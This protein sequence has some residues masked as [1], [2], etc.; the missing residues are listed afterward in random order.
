MFNCEVTI[1]SLDLNEQQKKAVYCDDKRICVVAG[2]G[3]GK[4][5]TLIQRIGRLIQEDKCRGD[6]IL[7][8]TFTNAAAF[9]M[10]ERFQKAFGTLNKGVPFFGTFHAF[11]YSLIAHDI[12][13]RD[14]VGYTKVPMIVT[15]NKMKMIEKEVATR[16]GINLTEEKLTTG[17]NLSPKEEYDYAIFKKALRHTMREKNVITFNMLCYDVCALFEN[18]YPIV[19]QY[20]K[21]YTYILTDEFQ[22]TDPKQWDFIKSFK[23]SDIMVVGDALQT[24]YS[25]R[26]ASP[27]IIMGLAEDPQWTTIKLYDNYR[28]TEQI[29]K[30]ANKMS[31]YAKE[32]YRIV[33]TAHKTGDP[34]IEDRFS[35]PGWGKTCDDD[36][37]DQLLIDVKK[38]DGECAILCRTN[39]EVKA[40]TE[41][42]QE[43]EIE[44]STTKP[45]EEAIQVIKSSRDNAHLIEWLS[46]FL[47]AETYGN[48]I[49][50]VTMNDAKDNIDLQMS[51]F[52]SFTDRNIV[53]SSK[54]KTIYGVRSIL[55]SKSSDIHTKQIKLKR[56]LKIKKVPLNDSLEDERAVVEYLLTELEKTAEADIYVGTIH[57]AK[58]LE[59]DSVILVGVNGWSFKIDNDDNRNCLYVGITRAKNHLKVYFTMR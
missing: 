42:L 50:T 48:W 32:S 16:L 25:F 31:K 45:N 8:L 43:N 34:V 17:K 20:R 49:R 5:A 13:V 55:K 22:D 57:S 18:D 39:K 1:M 19:Q 58:G 28:S 52:K 59:Y 40:I 3:S 7:A 21:K 12:R 11:C 24:L 35:A 2:A 15:E 23:D 46:S 29:V 4:T 14:A 53:I 47:D 27:E 41:F 26:G 54:L 30:Y 36:M 10:K 9:E 38:A 44:V 51:L 37:L 33:M 6:N 56:L